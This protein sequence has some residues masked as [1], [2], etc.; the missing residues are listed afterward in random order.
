MNNALLMTACIKPVISDHILIADEKL[1]LDSYLSA[2][3]FWINKSNFDSLIFCE[4]SNYQYDYSSLQDLAKKKGKIL[5]IILF[6]GS[7]DV[8]KYGKGFAEGEIIEFAINNS[9]LLKNSES[10]YKVTGRVTIQNINKILETHI[11]DENY[12][13]L[14]APGAKSVDTRFFKTNTKFY[15]SNLMEKYHEV[16][17]DEGVYI[18]K[19]FYK[20]LVG[21]TPNQLKVYPIVKGLS[22]STGTTY[23]KSTLGILLRN[24]LVLFG[25]YKVK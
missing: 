23:E 5:E 8:L 18:E 20:Y 13:N 16:R 15:K 19:V 3:E 25:K 12:F 11:N 10:F 22:G 24:V 6:Q 7:P 17:D 2:L 4:N 1:R 9:L 14:A 21:K